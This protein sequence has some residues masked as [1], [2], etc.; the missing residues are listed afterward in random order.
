MPA[1]SIEAIT[2]TA[3]PGSP[4]KVMEKDAASSGTVKV[5]GTVMLF[6]VC[7]EMVASSVNRGRARSASSAMRARRRC[8]VRGWR[9]FCGGAL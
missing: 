1:V 7:A 8:R 2:V 6:A 5:A 3:A 4:E 9:C